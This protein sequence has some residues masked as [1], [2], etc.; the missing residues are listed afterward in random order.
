VSTRLNSFWLTASWSSS[1]RRLRSDR[2]ESSWLR[3]YRR[4]FVTAIAACA[5]SSSISS[6]SAALNAAAPSFSA[7]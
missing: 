1:A 3:S 5:A 2:I 7:R 4:A 6:W